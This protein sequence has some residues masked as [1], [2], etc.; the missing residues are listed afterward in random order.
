MTE[1]LIVAGVIVLAVGLR[2]FLHP[3]PRKL[4]AA[5]ILAASYLTGYFLTGLHLVGF[6]AVMGWFLL[7]WYELLTRIRRLRLPIHKSLRQ[8]SPPNPHRFPHLE[9]FTG[10]IEEQGFEYVED[11]GWEWD[12]LKQFFR[13]FYHREKKAQVAVCLNEQQNMAFAYIAISS[14]AADGRTFRTWNYPFSDTMRLPP[15]VCLNRV[16]DADSFTELLESHEVFLDAFAFAASDLVEERA[17]DLPELMERETSEQIRHNLDC[18]LISEA[19]EDPDTF[20]YSWRGLFFLY[21]QVV[22]DMVKLS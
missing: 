9:E 18:G 17:E 21:R 4:G 15:S 19:K 20:R 13:I 3:V 11:T 1:F 12:D 6:A 14:R 5:A 16:P 22:K 10:E 2:T 8:Q 7:P